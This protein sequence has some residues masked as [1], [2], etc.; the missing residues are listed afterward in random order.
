MLEA[1]IARKPS[2]ALTALIDVVFILLIF[3]LLVMQFHQYQQLPL[4]MAAATNVAPLVADD[5][6]P[7]AVIL[8][9]DALCY[10]NKRQVNCANLAAQLALRHS[11]KVVLYFE[12]EVMLGRILKAHEALLAQG[13]DVHLATHVESLR[14]P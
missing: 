2:I 12:S 5:A 13:F 9:N 3:F 6:K 11:G 10:A 1:R 7:V 8:A 14:G 4:A